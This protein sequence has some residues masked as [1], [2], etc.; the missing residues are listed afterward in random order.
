L[1][2]ALLTIAL[3]GATVALFTITLLV[4]TLVLASAVCSVGSESY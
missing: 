2:L 4:T 1:V 3:F